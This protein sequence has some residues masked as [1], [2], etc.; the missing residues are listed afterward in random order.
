MKKDL[1]YILFLASGVL[2]Y[3]L[4]EVFAQKP[5]NWTVT[6]SNTDKNPFGAYLIDERMQDLFPGKRIDNVNLTLYELQDSLHE[7]ML[8]LASS[9]NPSEED[10][11][12]LLEMV[13]NGANAFIAAEYFYGAFSDT[14]NL[15]T[16]DYFFNENLLE[17]ITRD[18]TA[19]LRFVEPSIETGGYNYR[20]NNAHNYFSSFDTARTAVLAMNDLDEAVLIRS[21]W[22][23]GNF[24]LSTTPLAF[25]NN[26]LLF[27]KNYEFVSKAL[28]YLPEEN[29]IW[30]EYYQLGR[31]VSQTP[32]RFI[33][34]SEPLKWGYYI[35]ILS[36]LLFI[37]F[38]AKRKQRII[39]VIT[40]LANT[41]L[42]FVSTI[43]NLYYYKKDHRSI[44]EKRIRFFLD[45]L[46]STYRL[47]YKEGES[48]WLE[49][50]ATK[51]GQPQ[52]NIRELFDL[53]QRVKAK[54]TITEEELK[55]LN[56]RIDEINIT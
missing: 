5:V 28:S 40:P 51:T 20:R 1:K 41:T 37:L 55:E 19:K 4:V 56:N 24:F 38:E 35:A 27:E 29:L 2:L 7:N 46:R 47:P 25:T 34:G 36:L 12:A 14:L 9:F 48:S 11:V 43:S 10:A 23:K 17:N 16:Q 30:T 6:F 3:I 42:E 21:T 50:I 53:I 49:S 39:P 32:L 45:Q 8:V 18:D 15:I 13:G 26:Y 33:L 22:G 54:T 52:S 44:A 31:M